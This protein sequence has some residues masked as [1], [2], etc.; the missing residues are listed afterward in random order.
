MDIRLDYDLLAD[1]LYANT[2]EPFYTYYDPYDNGI[3]I[4]REVS[5]DEPVGFVITQYSERNLSYTTDIPFAHVIISLPKNL[6][7]SSVME[8]IDG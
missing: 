1:T 2:T 3:L 4:R 7:E 6:P 5:N 8:V